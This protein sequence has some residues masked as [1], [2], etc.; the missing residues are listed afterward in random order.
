MAM[1]AEGSRPGRGTFGASLTRSIDFVLASCKDSGLINVPENTDR[2]PMYGHGFASMFLAEVY[3]VAQRP[4]LPD[5]LRRAIQL[6]VNSQNAE[7][8]WRYEPRRE[9]ADI[10]VT[11]CQVMALRAA[12]NAGIYIPSETMDRAV[13]YV[14]RCQNSDGGFSYTLNQPGDSRFP[15]SAAG[16]VALYSAGIY[17]SEEVQRG[18]EY[19]QRHT[20]QST[21]LSEQGYF[22]YGHYYAAQAMWH[23]NGQRWANWYPLIRDFLGLR[24]RQDGAWLDPISP[25]YGTAM[26]CL[27]M[28]MPNNYL[29]IFKR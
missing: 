1:L 15:R 17:D 25:E 9:D 5:K 19:L 21:A 28:Q 11:V 20:P 2:G 4:A 14:K 6:T 3:G 26:A 7:G 23:A 24:Q 10:S 22:L 8:G 13:E 27:I 18:L 29:P 12:K 16:V